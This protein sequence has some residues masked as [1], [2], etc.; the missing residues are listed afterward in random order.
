ML[1]FAT[2]FRLV[3]A[4]SMNTG[5]IDAGFAFEVLF[6]FCFV[7]FVFLLSERLSDSC[8]CSDWTEEKPNFWCLWKE[9]Y[10]LSL[11][12]ASPYFFRSWFGIIFSFSFLSLLQLLQT[13]LQLVVSILTAAMVQ[14]QHSEPVLRN[15]GPMNPSRLHE[16]FPGCMSCMSCL[17]IA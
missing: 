12:M 8:H 9:N 15:G 13:P 2:F 10:R 7:L 17:Y 16:G 5:L 6:L 1:C 3:S 4:L 11:S 14:G